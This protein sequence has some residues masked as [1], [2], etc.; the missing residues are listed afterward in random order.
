MGLAL[1]SSQVAAAT[2][3]MLPRGMA[4]PPCACEEAGTASPC[5]PGLRSLDRAPQDAFFLPLG[6]TA[7]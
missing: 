6:E 7:W 1:S 5:V 4:L 2:I 3:S